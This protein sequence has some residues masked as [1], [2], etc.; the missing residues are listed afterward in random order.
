MHFKYIILAFISHFNYQMAGSYTD[1]DDFLTLEDVGQHNQVQLEQ[2]KES[3]CAPVDQLVT[4]ME[5]EM[6]WYYAQEPAYLD[7]LK[8]LTPKVDL[9]AL[10]MAL[11]TASFK[12][13]KELVQYYLTVPGI[14]INAVIKDGGTALMMAAL[15]GRQDI[16]E[17]LLQVPAIHINMRD[18]YKKTALTYAHQKYNINIVKIIENKI[19]DLAQQAVLLTKQSNLDKL[20][21]IVLQIGA[22]ELTK[23]LDTLLDTAFSINSLP[24]ATFLLLSAKNPKKALSRF[25]FELVN[26]TSH[27]FRLCMDIAYAKPN[28]PIL[29]NLDIYAAQA[30]EERP[31]KKTSC[32][33]CLKKQCIKR[34]GKCQQVY[35]CT[36]TCQ[37]AHWKEHK[38]ICKES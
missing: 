13:H 29:M 16:A 9:N 35:Y 17:I 36:D 15:Q 12:G 38:K 6:Q 26:P 24:I 20:K 11:I 31:M 21:V 34:C 2:E 25:P 10:N 3:N 18:N 22:A 27:L 23:I 5:L 14:N 4:E 30:L 32:A 1:Q 33:F 8:K 7:V 28:D 19:C 37:K